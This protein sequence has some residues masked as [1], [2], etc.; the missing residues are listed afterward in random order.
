MPSF[1]K[2]EFPFL[3]V[4]IKPNENIFF[5]SE[6]P[7]F[8]A[9]TICFRSFFKLMNSGNVFILPVVL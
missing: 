9:A 8:L 2:G 7:V 4:Q 6:A 5:W 1:S 3:Y